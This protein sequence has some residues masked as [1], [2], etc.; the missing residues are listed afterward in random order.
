MYY[1]QSYCILGKTGQLSRMFKITNSFLSFQEDNNPNCNV[2][3]NLYNL[4]FSH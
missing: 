2:I 4:N 1:I 3:A